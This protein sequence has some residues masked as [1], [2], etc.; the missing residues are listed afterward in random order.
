MDRQTDKLI[1]GGLGNLQFLQ[2][3]RYRRTRGIRDPKK[4]IFQKA[5]TGGCGKAEL[6]EKNVFFLFDCFRIF[7]TDFLPDFFTHKFGVTFSHFL[8]LPKVCVTFPKCGKSV[9]KCEEVYHSVC[10]S[11]QLHKVTHKDKVT[12]K[13]DRQFIAKGPFETP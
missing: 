6:L 12:G 2:V 7:R 5:G 13:C 10:K 1:W 3:N 9:R 4:T 11:H 8:T